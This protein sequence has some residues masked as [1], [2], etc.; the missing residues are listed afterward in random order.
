MSLGEVINAIQSFNRREKRK[1]KEN[2]T[3]IYLLADLVGISNTRLYSDK[4]KY[5]QIE[6]LFP[7]VFDDEASREARQKALD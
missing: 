4:A 1:E 6:E 5:P 7:T 2:L 3:Y